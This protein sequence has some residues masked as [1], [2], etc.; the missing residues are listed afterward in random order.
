LITSIVKEQ[1]STAAILR[2]TAIF[3][4]A[5]SRQAEADPTFAVYC[6]SGLDPE[7]SVF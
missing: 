7:S 4:E 2:P 6:H 5:S 1:P 3:A